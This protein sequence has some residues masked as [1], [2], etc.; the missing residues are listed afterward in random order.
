MTLGLDLRL[1]DREVEDVHPVLDCGFDRGDDLGRPVR[2]QARVRPDQGP[3][4]ADVRARR[5]ARHRW[6]F[7]GVVH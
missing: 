2:A 7:A 1:A 6:P 4:V 3:V 5:D